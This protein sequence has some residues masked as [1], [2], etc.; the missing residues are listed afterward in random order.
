M[1]VLVT[2]SSKHGATKEIAERI[3]AALRQRGQGA[4]A[5]PVTEVSDL[6]QYEAFVIGSAVYMGSWTKEATAFVRNNRDV[7]ARHPVWLFSSGPTGGTTSPAPKQIAEF[8]AS[9]R[10]KDH[11]VFGGALDRQQLS[12]P[13][14]LIVSAVKAPMGD[15]RD[16]HVIDAWAERIGDTL[17]P[18]GTT[19]Q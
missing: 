4:V 5:R 13:E 12:I 18:T 3:A 16:W 9:I 8:D 10:P 6:N 19:A 2:Y 15:F 11:Q 7:L 17:A 14:R 1:S